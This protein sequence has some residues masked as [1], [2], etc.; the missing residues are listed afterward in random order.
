MAV[1]HR[2]IALACACA[3]SA[4]GGSGSSGGGAPQPEGVSPAGLWSG[5]DPISGQDLAG[6]I[7]ADGEFRFYRDDGTQYV[8]SV[9]TTSSGQVTG[10]FEGDAEYDFAFPDGSINGQGALTGWLDPINSQPQTFSI[11]MS[12]TD[13]N[14][15]TTGSD[16]WAF[17][18]LYNQPVTVA[19]LVGTYSLFSHPGVVLTVNA[20]GTVTASQDPSTG[21][22]F[23]GTIS[24]VDAAHPAYDFSGSFTNCQGNSQP[25]NGVQ[26][27]GLAFALPLPNSGGSGYQLIAMLTGD[28]SGSPR[29]VTYVA[30]AN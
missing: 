12:F 7:L 28:L 14:G 20:D 23:S 1:K 9:A 8:G 13:A 21:C 17:S 2:L 15:T 29:A 3:L 18:A 30:N 22:V 19:A 10:S 26:L 6:V 5:V 24:Q 11:S 27:S 4:C 16:Q 25:F